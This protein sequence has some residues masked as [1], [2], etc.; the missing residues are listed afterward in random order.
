MIRRSKTFGLVLLTCLLVG[1]VVWHGLNRLDAAFPPPLDAISPNSAELLD[2]DGQLLRAFTTQEGRWRLKTVASDVDPLL[3]RMLVAYEDRRFYQ[4]SGVDGLALGRAS[5]QLIRHGRI[6]SGA[7]TLSMQVARLIEPRKSRSFLAKTQQALRAIQI[8]HRLD[9]AA[10]LDLYLTHAPYGGN[11]EGVRA[12]S[13]AY[14]GKEPK[15]LTPAQAALLVALPQL[16]ER[17]RPDRFADNAL[18]ARD[19]V[20]ARMEKAGIVSAQDRQLASAVPIPKTRLELPMLAAHVGDAER[21][22]RPESLTYPTT[23]KKDVQAALETVARQAAQKLPPKVSVAILAA[24]IRTG[25]ILARVGSAAYL[26]ASRS[27][28]IDMTRIKRSPGSTLKPLIY[29]LAFEQG[30]IAQDTVIEDRPADFAGYRPK[31]F[32]MHYQG[33]VTIRDALQLSLNVPAVRLLEAVGPSQ[34]LARLKRADIRIDLPQAETPGLAIALGGAGTTLKDLVGLYTALARQGSAIRLRD[35]AIPSGAHVQPGRLLEPVAA[36]NVTDILSGVA[37]PLGALTGRIAY[38]TGTSYGYRDGWSIGYDGRTVI[39]V[40]IGRADNSAIPGLTGYGT[41]APVLF[42][43]FARSKLPQAPLPPPPEGALRIAKSDLTPGLRRFS[44][45]ASGLIAL[46]AREKPPMIVYPPEGAHVELGRTA[47][48]AQLP[49]VLK[50]Q[51]GRAPF[52]WLANGQALP[53]L[54][55]TRTTRWTPD[56]NGY[57]TLTVI[58]ASGRSASVGIFLQ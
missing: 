12:A 37:P 48:G 21:R 10:I 3:L 57:S 40:W 33:D 53:D 18:A 15:H 50:L 7:S 56:G 11:L 9:K 14:F 44:R 1:G 27:G 8:E 36:W 20:L 55:R 52:R 4:H 35:C 49:L 45:D 41:A 29:G 51:A 47:D 25:E 38:K 22:K 43:A 5:L 42:E 16:P 34:L 24:D 13:L 26:D 39:G 58:D 28:W 31:N 46:N 19:R 32:D 17:R 23:L 2:A 6:V 30:L 54:A